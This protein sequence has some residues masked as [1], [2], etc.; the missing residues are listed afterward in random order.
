MSTSPPESV[1]SPA[2]KP[3]SPLAAAPLPLAARSHRK[4]WIAA[5]ATVAIVIAVYA[6]VWIASRLSHSETDDAFVEAHIVNVAPEAVSGHIVRFLVEENDRV[7]QGQILAEIDPIPYQDKVELA[8][9]KVEEAEADLRRQETTLVRVKSEVPIQIEI[10]KRTLAA[11]QA[12][13]ARAKSPL[14]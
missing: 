5:A 11:A 13:E 6:L 4:L 12:D 14:G 7:R 3:P 9:S 1:P 10:A 2:A 8:R